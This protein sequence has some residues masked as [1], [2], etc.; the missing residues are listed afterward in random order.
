LQGLV[1]PHHAVVFDGT[2]ALI[3]HEP[4]LIEKVFAR[5]V[6]KHAFVGR[7]VETEG[8]GGS[9]GSGRSRGSGSSRGSSGDAA[10]CGRDGYGIFDK[11]AS[12]HDNGSFDSGV[13][14][15]KSAAE[16]GFRR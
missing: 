4:D 2:E 12:M 7:K 15:M 11:I 5:M 10:Q 3:V 14:V 1:A 8:G 6:A 13:K 16:N 9:S